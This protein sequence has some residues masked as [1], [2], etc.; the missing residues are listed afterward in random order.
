MGSGF[1]VVDSDFGETSNRRR[2]IDRSIIIQDAA[3]SV[4][5]IFAKA[6]ISSNVKIGEGAA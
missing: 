3:M 1:G 5:G 4:G 6:D 2:C